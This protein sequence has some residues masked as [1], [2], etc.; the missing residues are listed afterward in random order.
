MSR[1]STP[2]KKDFSSTITSTITPTLSRISTPEKKDIL[3]TSRISTPEKKELLK[4]DRMS[5]LST[6]YRRS[7]LSNESKSVETKDR[8]RQIL[9]EIQQ[10]VNT[11]LCHVTQGGWGWGK[12]KCHQMW[13]WGC[14]KSAEKVSCII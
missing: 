2:E 14:L 9:A 4:T 13:D 3:S 11:S 12:K 5:K 1:I 6:N 7:S 8:S 10:Q